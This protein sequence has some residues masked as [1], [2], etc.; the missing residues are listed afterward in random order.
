MFCGENANFLYLLDT[1]LS[2]RETLLLAD[3]CFPLA[4]VEAVS[5]DLVAADGVLVGASEEFFTA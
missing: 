1:V 5:R 3:V 4:V 2:L